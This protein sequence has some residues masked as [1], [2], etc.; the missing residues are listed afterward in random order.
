MEYQELRPSSDLA[1]IVRCYWTLR[2]AGDRPTQPRE[3]IL[4]DGCCE[5][6][7]NRADVFRKRAADGVWH[8]QPRVL[9]AGQLEKVL[10]VM[11]S[12]V[13]DLFSVRFQP[14]G[15]HLLTGLAV[16]EIRGLQV[17]LSDVLRPIERAMGDLE[18]LTP[19]QAVAQVEKTLRRFVRSRSGSTGAVEHAVD[20]IEASKGDLPLELVARRCEMSRRQLERRFLVVVGL[21]PKQFARIVRFQ[22]LLDLVEVEGPKHWSSLALRGG[23][24]DQSHMIR[25]FRKFAN[26]S[27]A[28]Y[29]A[30]E[31][32]LA[33]H[34]SGTDMSH[35]SNPASD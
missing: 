26:E 12:G 15:L 2:Q 22:S 25:E 21:R 5:I 6:V 34:L 20:L 28:A 30:G 14:T 9:V 10:E 24:F 31:H 17:E 8:E 27:P 29:F 16:A 3:K 11:P 23:Y 19:R 1:R 35:S 13:I 4:P 7:F 33:T 32:P 18:S